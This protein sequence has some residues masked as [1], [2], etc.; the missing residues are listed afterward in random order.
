MISCRKKGGQAARGG[1]L[2]RKE[3]T[4]RMAMAVMGMALLLVC[5]GCTEDDCVYCGV[6]ISKGVRW[7]DSGT[8]AKDQDTAR[9]DSAAPDDSG[10]TT[11]EE[12]DQDESSDAEAILPAENMVVIE[13]AAFMM[14]C[15]E[16]AMPNCTET[17][18]A[19]RHEV[20]VPSFEID[21]Y[22][23]SKKDFEACVAAG[24]CKNKQGD[25]ARYIGYD[26]EHPYC[27]IGDAERPDTMP[28]NCVSWYGARVYCAWV[29]K[30]L[31]S[32]AEWEF[33]A[34]GSDDRWYPW[35]N[36]PGPSC[37]TA[38]MEG[39]SDWGCDSGFAMSVG[40]KEAGKSPFGL[41]D[42]AGNVWEWVADDWHEN[43]DGAP[44]D[45]SAWVDA[46]RPANR[47][48]RGGSFMTGAD[49]AFEFLAY[50]HYGAPADNP[51]VSYGFR[52]AR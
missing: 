16:G 25:P 6:D 42:M 41:Y 15:E 38:V 19:P 4:M 11:D 29:G 40:S 8:A 32:E 30:R 18:A 52:C 26:G 3:G 20:T 36:T 17:N 24:A 23:V 34:R 48:Q 5:L 31:P 51:G 2:K 44:T 39:A 46:A 50:G 14:G 35:G 43:Y 12:I 7:N 1:S 13:G 21:V 49:E 47:V 37:N 33:A 22:E 27:V 10:I 28:A 45:G 9:P